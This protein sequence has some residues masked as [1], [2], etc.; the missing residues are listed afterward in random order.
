MKLSCTSTMVPG[1]TL[2]QKALNLK[3]YGYDG[4]G[5]FIDYPDWNEDLKKEVLDLEKNTGVHVCEFMFGG[6]DYGHLMEDDETKVAATTKMYTDAAKMCA[7]LGGAISE[8]EYTLGAQDPLPLFD[9]YKKMSADKA[10]LF[11]E[12]YAG[13]ASNVEGTKDAYVLLEPCNRYETP[14]LNNMEDCVN[15]VKALNMKNVGILADI[16]HLNFEEKDVANEIR[17]YG[18]MIKYVHLGDSNRL[19]PGDGHTNWEEVFK[20]LKEVGFDGYC[21]LECSF[22]GKDPETALIETANY[23]KQYM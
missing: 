7:L 8:L 2:T 23:L 5:V 14:Y 19:L 15:A 11:A 1:E 9:V 21:S 17:K 10:Q 22:G 18:D 12:R 6:D 3:K 4:I 16:F 20:A 13:I